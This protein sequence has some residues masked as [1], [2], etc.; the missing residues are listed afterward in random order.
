METPEPRTVISIL[1]L[2]AGAAVT[3]FLVVNEKDTEA[4]EEVPLLQL[5]YY[6]DAAEL[7]GTANDGRVLYKLTTRRAQQVSDDNSIELTEIVMN[8]GAPGGLPWKV[9]ADRGRI[10]EGA[11]IIELAGNVV[12]ISGEAAPNQTVINTQTLDIEPATM[13][14][15]TDNRVRLTY[16]QRQLNATGMQ[17]DFKV[18]HL[19]LLSNVNGKFIP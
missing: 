14:A 7:T 8:Y 17:A 9:R 15:S 10:P 16:N 5:A 2:A 19:K 11:R 18:N 4:T 12:A 3:S 1:M 6:L 13:R